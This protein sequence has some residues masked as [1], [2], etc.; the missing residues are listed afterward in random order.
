MREEEELLPRGTQ[1]EPRA[2]DFELGVG[3]SLWGREGWGR[4][5]G[6]LIVIH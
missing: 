1:P 4:G 2:V 5:G 6:V 3:T